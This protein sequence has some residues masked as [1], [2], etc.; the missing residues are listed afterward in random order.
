MDF[1]EREQFADTLGAVLREATGGA[2]RTVLIGGEAGIGKTT[3]VERFIA[4][5]GRAARVLWGACDAL[6]TPRP[7]GPLHD[8]MR[9]APAELGS[10]LD[11]GRDWLDIASALLAWLARGAA[12]T[13]I[14]VEDAHWADEATLDLLR[15]LGRRMSKTRALLVVT[16]RD[17]E[18]APQHSLR[19]VLG[20]L[21]SRATTRLVL[22]R[23]SEAAV[24]RLAQQAGRSADGLYAATGGNPFFVTEVLAHGAGGLPATVRDAV[25][26]RAARLSPPARQVLDLASIVPGAIEQWLVAAICGAPAPQIEEC[27]ASG[28]L[29]L[30]DDRLAFRHDLARRAVEDALPAP[31][32]R[33]LHAQVLAALTGDGLEPVPLA[34][35]VHHAAQAGDAPSVLRFAPQAARQASG[36][37]AHCQAADHYSTALRYAARLPPAELAELLEGRS[38][39]CYLMGESDAAIQARQEATEI[40]RRLDRPEREGDGVR[41]LSRLFWQAGNKQE[42]DRYA[43]E[44]IAILE[45]LAPGPALA[46]AYSNRAQL[47][48]LA[49]EHAAALGW[50]RRALVL[51]WELGETQIMVHALT[52]IGSDELRLGDEAGRAK[53]ETALATALAHE[54]HDDVAR[55]YTT[56][57]C[58]AI[59]VRDYARGLDYLEKGLAYATARDLDTYGPYL[60]GWRAR[61]RFEQ[62]QWRAAEEDARRAL[63]DPPGAAVIP[64]PA[65]ITLGHLYARCGEPGAMDLLDSA[66][67]IAMPTGEPQRLGPLAA[68]RAEAAWWRGDPAQTLAEARFGYDRVAH[69]GDGWMLGQL[70]F[71]MGRAGGLDARPDGLARPYD[72][73][74]R[75]EWRAAVAEWERLG[76]P[77]E[78]GLALAEGDVVAQLAALEL[79][80]ELGARPAGEALRRKLRAAGVKGIPRGPR[81][82]TRGNPFGLTERENEVLRLLGEGLS[83]AEIA[84]RLSISAKTV[85][86]H[87]SAILAKIGAHT[88]GE[89][90]AAARRG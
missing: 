9:Q 7:L 39:E 80:D 86:H 40:W 14:V 32:A 46:M 51:A 88:R 4:E 28:L 11:S 69:T 13:V 49:E 44:A 89:A 8:I 5:Q 10:L 62:G 48:G 84:T 77:F 31:R 27:A 52:N 67:T 64:L 54:L 41:W 43:D 70:A 37:G 22:P 18:L 42:A 29:L 35:L 45:P 78:R 56:L 34:R 1:L 66:R 15:F 87:V 50:G 82:V 58:A 55:A 25:L 74:L 83:N 81:P 24:D 33:E 63:R 90:V 59:E 21:P 61:T 85:D 6:L 36:A 12:P 17:D 76:C 57:A 26:G 73:L 75:G 20:D 2:G 72:L 23:L 16:Y 38:F 19:R 71:W 79:F 65:L 30:R 53:L 3:L 60:R 68:A 47:H